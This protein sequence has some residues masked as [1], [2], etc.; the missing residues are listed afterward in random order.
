MYLTQLK[1]ILVEA[2][3]GTFSDG[4]P[5]AEWRGINIG[6]EYPIEP[7]N[8]PGIWVDYDD[9]DNLKIA[10]IAHMEEKEDDQGDPVHFTRWKF[11][12]Y[13]SMT[14]VALTSFE[15]DRLYDEVVGVMAFGPDSLGPL[16][17]RHIIE[18]NDYIALNCNFD[19]IQ[20]RGNNAAPGTPWGT[21]E[22]IYERS[23]NIQVI[24]EFVPDATGRSLLRLSEIKLV[25]AREYNGPPGGNSFPED[26]NPPQ[27]IFDWQ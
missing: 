21:D 11:T 15:R 24:G 12:G 9:T 18:N 1:T 6:I 17:F 22:I 8:Y 2:L 19:Q 25:E 5:V 16:N 3:R 7:H 23:L 13:V 26:P 20:P 14:I 27:S 10:G 4:Y